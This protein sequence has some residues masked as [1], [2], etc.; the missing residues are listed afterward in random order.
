MIAGLQAVVVERKTGLKIRVR[1]PNAFWIRHSLDSREQ[2]SLVWVAAIGAASLLVRY[3]WHWG[4]AA[5]DE[6]QVGAVGGRV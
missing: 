2:A 1:R 3:Y 6:T 5:V 4:D